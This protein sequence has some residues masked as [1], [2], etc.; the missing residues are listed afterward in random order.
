MFLYKKEPKF[1]LSAMFP[2]RANKEWVSN[3]IAFSASLFSLKIELIT[4]DS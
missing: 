4:V 1:C 3:A 2:E